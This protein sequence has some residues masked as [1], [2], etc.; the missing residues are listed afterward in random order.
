[1]QKGLLPPLDGSGDERSF[2]ERVKAELAGS[3]K[4]LDKDPNRKPASLSRSYCEICKKE[5]CN[6]YF[7]KTHMLKMHGINIEGG[8][9]PPGLISTV[10]GSNSNGPTG[11]VI[12][13][14]CKKELCSKY[15]LKVHL[16][17]TMS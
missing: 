9:P 10:G 2:L 11:G 14:I 7:M 13:Q 17:V 16:Q 3:P 4:K 12:C 6:K 8:P 5:L 1:M 15:F